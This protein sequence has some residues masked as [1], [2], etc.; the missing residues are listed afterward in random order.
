MATGDR[1]EARNFSQNSPP[2]PPPD[3]SRFQWKRIQAST[4]KCDVC[5]KRNTKG[6]MVGCEH[7]RWQTCHRTCPADLKCMHRRD[8]R[9]CAHQ[10]DHESH[11]DVS[12]DNGS[13][14]A[15]RTAADAGSARPRPRHASVRGRAC[16]SMNGRTRSRPASVRRGARVGAGTSGTPLHSDHGGGSSV[17]IVRARRPRVS[18]HI[19]VS[20]SSSRSSSASVSGDRRARDNPHIIPRIPDGSTNASDPNHNPLAQTDLTAARSR[21]NSPSLPSERGNTNFSGSDNTYSTNQADRYTALPASSPSSIFRHSPV[22]S[23]CNAASE[24][25]DTSF[26]E[27]E[28]LLFSA[29]NPTKEDLDCA[30]RLLAPRIHAGIILNLT[31]CGKCGS[32]NVKNPCGRAF[33]LAK[34]D[35]QGWERANIS[36]RKDS[37]HDACRT[38]DGNR[39]DEDDGEDDEDDTTPDNSDSG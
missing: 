38:M 32:H 25:Y 33:S 20:A 21:P 17:R 27:K 35:R 34:K 7:C 28:V 9:R 5:G 14:M 13:R 29:A 23:P 12:P 4:A 37:A 24:N 26:C 30:E 1:R 8:D 2:L 6:S 39:D 11:H 22:P 31:R 36:Q 15:R 16:A 19:I 10:C 3:H 18:R